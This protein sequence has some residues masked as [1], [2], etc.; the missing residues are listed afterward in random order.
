MLLAGDTGFFLG[1]EEEFLLFNKEDC[2]DV[3]WPGTSCC[4][5]IV[6]YINLG[7]S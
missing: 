5:F 2:T 4:G 6:E 7:V 3:V 1:F